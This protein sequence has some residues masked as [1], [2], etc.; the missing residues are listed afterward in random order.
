VLVGTA[1]EGILDC[2][3]VLHSGRSIPYLDANCNYVNE[4][5]L[6][7]DCGCVGNKTPFPSRNRVQIGLVAGVGFGNN[8]NEARAGLLR[9]WA[10]PEDRLSSRQKRSGKAERASD[11]DRNAESEP[12]RLG[13]RLC[14]GFCLS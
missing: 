3:K 1:S 2:H 9:R 6:D 7:D 12:P 10:S 5:V 4:L 11:S 13:P 8:H 14:C